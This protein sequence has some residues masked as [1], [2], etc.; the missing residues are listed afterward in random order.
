MERGIGARRR[1]ST[2]RSGRGSRRPGNQ[3][4]H[5]G[6]RRRGSEA[7]ASTR[8]T[9]GVHINCRDA[10]CAPDR[11]QYRLVGPITAYGHRPRPALQPRTPRLDCFAHGGLAP[12][13][14]N[15]VRGNSRVRGTT[16][17][18]AGRGSPAECGSARTRPYGPSSPSVRSRSW[19]KARRKI[20]ETCICDTP[21]SSAI[22]VWVRSCTNR[23]S[24]TLRSR[25]DR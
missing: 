17:A 3:G 8:E 6:R 11:M 20:R 18:A 15:P 2:S 10:T 7:T 21:I 23:S 16:G 14:P 13:Y 12:S 5:H 4:G 25:A 19:D 22:C 1:S 9:G 24:R